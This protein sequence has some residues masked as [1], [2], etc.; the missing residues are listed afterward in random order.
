LG[1]AALARIAKVRGGVE[2]LLELRRERL[3]HCLQKLAPRD[4]R[5]LLE[6]YVDS[7]GI[8]DWARAENVSA[9][10]VYSQLRRLRRKLHDCINRHLGGN[11]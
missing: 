4:R 10:T 11:L 1:E 7:T 8:S 3:T 5:M 6:C 9:N 2:E